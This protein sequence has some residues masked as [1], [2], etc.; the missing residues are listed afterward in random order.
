MG[1]PYGPDPGS[2]LKHDGRGSERR[3]ESSSGHET[4]LIVVEEA[5][6]LRM[7]ETDWKIGE[8]ERQEPTGSP[9]SLVTRGGDIR[10]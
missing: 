2:P 6:T 5:W 9:I 8:V 3:R 1:L 10:D 7:A 4:H